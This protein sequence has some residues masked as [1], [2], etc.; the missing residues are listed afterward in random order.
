MEEEHATT[1]GQSRQSLGKNRG[2]SDIGQTT[3][4]LGSRPQ[5]RPNRMSGD[6]VVPRRRTFTSAHSSVSGGSYVMFTSACR[7]R[8]VTSV[9]NTD[10]LHGPASNSSSSCVAVERLDVGLVCERRP[11]RR[12]LGLAERLFLNGGGVGVFA[13][14]VS[15]SA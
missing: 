12:E 1:F 7:P 4:L 15:A 9:C 2:R 6:G 5:A 3:D 10:P 8:R 13:S 14:G 11:E